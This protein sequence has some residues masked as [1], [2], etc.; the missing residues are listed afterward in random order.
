MRADVVDGEA[1]HAAL[2]HLAVGRHDERNELGQL[3]DERV[4]TVA[5]QLLALIARHPEN[6]TNCAVTAAAAA[7]AAASRGQTPRIAAAATHSCSKCYIEQHKLLTAVKLVITACTDTDR[8]TK[9]SYMF[10][11]HIIYQHS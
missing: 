6:R 4:E 10:S 3:A 5:A 1:Q 8:A 2:V 7:A 11:R 9:Y